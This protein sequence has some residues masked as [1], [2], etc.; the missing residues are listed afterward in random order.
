[1]LFLVPSRGSPGCDRGTLTCSTLRS[2]GCSAPGALS[3]A[4]PPQLRS[5]SLRSVMRSGKS[6]CSELE[7]GSPMPLNLVAVNKTESGAAV[8]HRF[9][10]EAGV[11]ERALGARSL[12]KRHL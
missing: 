8:C 7:D 9:S 10:G 11:R 4:V 1:M 5:T 6:V 12:W 2:F 3:S